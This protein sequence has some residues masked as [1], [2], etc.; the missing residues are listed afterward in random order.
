MYLPVGSYTSTVYTAI[1]EANYTEA[2]EILDV[3]LQNFPRSRAALSLLGYCYFKIGDFPSA[4]QCYE[5]LVTL[6]PEVEEYKFY[7][8][9]TLY[10]A[11]SRDIDKAA[12]MEHITDALGYCVE[13]EYP[14]KKIVIAGRSL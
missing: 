11:G 4:S 14:T 8:A 6:C 2:I 9:Q 7:Y 1:K 3:E 5:Q 13:L 10:K 12:S